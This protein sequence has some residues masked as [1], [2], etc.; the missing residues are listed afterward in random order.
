MFEWWWLLGLVFFGPYIL[1]PLVVKAAVKT[2]RRPVLDRLGDD[3][4]PIV[5]H[6]ALAAWWPVIVAEGF[7]PVGLF[8]LT[9]HMGTITAHLYL[10]RHPRESVVCGAFVLG[11]GEGVGE[12]YLECSVTYADGTSV[13]TLATATLSL[14]VTHPTKHVI[15]LRGE[16]DAAFLIRVQRAMMRKFGSGRVEALP[17]PD[18]WAAYILQGLEREGRRFC[19]VGHW[20]AD[21]ANG[22][23][24]MTW[25]GATLGVWGAVWPVT[26]IRRSRIDA[27]AAAMLRELGIDRA[28][29]RA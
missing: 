11:A 13:N 7:E 21:D 9:K 17:A 1:G 19:E 8:R 2:S 15:Q 20:Q 3:Q 16:R 12:P 23:F 4:I 29:P 22:C 25:K 27:A 26:P 5:L 10:F 24:R 18:G 28:M 14:P 6:R